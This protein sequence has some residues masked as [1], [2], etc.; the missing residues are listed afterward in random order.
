MDKKK[1][2]FVCVHNSARSQ[3]AEA[4]LKEFAGDK[5]DV[6]SAGLEPG[7][8]N[9]IVVEA[10][11]EVGIDISNNKTKSAFDFLKEGKRYHYVITVCNQAQAEKCPVF[12]NAI[13]RIHWGFSDP[14]KFEGSDKEKLDKIR[15]V[16]DN[17][18]ETIQA[19]LKDK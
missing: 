1:V 9:P 4:Y 2:L 5:F 18:K 6:E 8:L 16:R 7:L 3:M 12:P 14:S 15:S 17:I 19:W 10:M 11:K 13:E